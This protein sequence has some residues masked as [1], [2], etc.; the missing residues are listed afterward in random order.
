MFVVMWYDELV[1]YWWSSD[2]CPN[3]GNRIVR[4]QDLLLAS[5]VTYMMYVLYG[6]L[7]LSVAVSSM[8]V[9]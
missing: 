3:S 6:I 2:E 8:H 1:L 5:D 9:I 7:L 4:H